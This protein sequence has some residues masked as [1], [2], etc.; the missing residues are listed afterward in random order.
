ME[1]IHKFLR[2]VSESKKQSQSQKSSNGLTEPQLCDWLANQYQNQIDSEDENRSEC[3][4][5]D[6]TE[7]EKE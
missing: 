6:Q 2:Y 7:R 1:K 4:P 5:H 3:E